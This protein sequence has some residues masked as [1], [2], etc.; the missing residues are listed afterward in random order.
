MSTA[1]PVNPHKY[2]YF[3]S[4]YCR[5]TSGCED[6]KVRRFG[7]HTYCVCTYSGNCSCK[8]DSPIKVKGGA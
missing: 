2:T 8:S 3:S 5:S 1:K 7:K 6:R 4:K